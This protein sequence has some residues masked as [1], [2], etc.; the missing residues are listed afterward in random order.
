[1]AF[2]LQP[3]APSHN[4]LKWQ[5]FMVNSV[6]EHKVNP[7]KSFVLSSMDYPSKQIAES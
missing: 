3:K 5:H 1:M 2:A 4:Y 6:Q 7:C